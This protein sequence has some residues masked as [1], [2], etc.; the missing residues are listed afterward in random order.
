[1]DILRAEGLVKSYSRRRVVDGVSLSV[2]PG[3]I[4]GLLGPNGAGKSTSF[5]MMCGLVKPDQGKVFLQ[6][7]DVTTWPLHQRSREGGMGYL[8]QQ[9]SVFANLSTQDNLIGMMQFLG[10]S[11][12]DQ[13]LRTDELIDQFKLE[14]VRRSKAGRL[15]GGEK[16]RLE[17]A[18]CLIAEPKII[19]LD[20]P[21]AGIDPVTVQSVQVVIK[22]LAETGIAILITDHA[23][24][25]ILQITD[26]TYV[27]SDGRILT[28]GTAAEIVTHPDVKR[29]YL[30]DIEMI[31]N[32][33]VSTFQPA[34]VP[35]RPSIRPAGITGQ[36][37][38]TPA[39]LTMHGLPSQT[40]PIDSG[41]ATSESAEGPHEPRIKFSKPRRSR[42]VIA[43]F[44]ANDLD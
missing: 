17:I 24:R 3:E 42:K 40:I 18:R 31:A 23:A 2:S 7:I 6:G 27:V 32:D 30:G 8:P 28:S 16:R 20:E 1:M 29:K 37:D 44:R 11:R 15:S 43:P 9:S 36:E 21:F 26:R 41:E 14:H 33:P 13:R 4:V 5:K 12:K 10:F 39:V 34:S 22:E 35:L 38:S 25:E 19:M